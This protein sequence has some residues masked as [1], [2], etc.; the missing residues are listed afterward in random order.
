LFS[1][2]R[3]L[4]GLEL[5]ERVVERLPVVRR[6]AGV[7]PG[8]VLDQEPLF[9]PV[10]LQVDRCDDVGRRRGP[11]ARSSRAFAFSFGT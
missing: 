11:V 3:E 9:L 7:G 5:L 6:I 8:P 2:E 10:R 1:I 4:E